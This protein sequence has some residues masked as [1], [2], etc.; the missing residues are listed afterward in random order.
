MGTQKRL[1]TDRIYT[2]MR[3]DIIACKKAPGER[4]TEDSLRKKFRTS[5]TP[6]REAMRRLE[7][8]GLV[9]S[10]PHRGIFVSR[11]SSRDVREIY[12]I[13]E[14]LEGVAVR[15]AVQNIRDN[16]KVYLRRLLQ[17]LE[18]SAAARDQESWHN[19]NGDLHFYL[20]KLSGN[21]NLFHVIEG[22]KKRVFRYHKFSTTSQETMNQ[23]VTQHRNVVEAVIEGDAQRAEKEMAA[24][25]RLVKEE[26]LRF[27]KDFPV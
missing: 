15:M 1:L 23:Y 11:I 4:L 24:H 19:K 3:N 7:A 6:I 14:V 20:I 9:F 2:S 26:I 18:R 21:K 5:N 25:L 22:L 27:L 17:D 12:E 10:V 8:E 16:D 13:R